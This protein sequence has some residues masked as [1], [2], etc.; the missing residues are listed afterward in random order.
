MCVDH[1]LFIHSSVNNHP[2]CFHVPAIANSALMTLEYIMSFSIIVFSGYTY[3][4]IY[5][6][7]CPVMGLLGY[8]VVLFLIF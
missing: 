1:S 8:A 5:I 2:G 3:I 6:Y 4:Y 7:I